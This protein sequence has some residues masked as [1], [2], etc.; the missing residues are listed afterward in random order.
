MLTVRLDKQQ[1]DQLNQLSKRK[2]MS[3]SELV[4]EALGIYLDSE[5]ASRTPYELGADLFGR[6][7]NSVDGS[8]TYKAKIKEK[9]RAKYSH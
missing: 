6:G 1:E 8:T 3:K 7:G 5:N 2:R 4:K 9:L